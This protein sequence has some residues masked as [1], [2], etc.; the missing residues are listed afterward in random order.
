MVHLHL[1]IDDNTLGI[2]TLNIIKFMKVHIRNFCL[3]ASVDI[4]WS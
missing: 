3:N 4:I 1:N 2:K